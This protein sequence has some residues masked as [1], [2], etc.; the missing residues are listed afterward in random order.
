MKKCILLLVFASCATLA[1]A[2][3]R[4]GVVN[5]S[6]AFLHQKPDY[7]SPLETQA[8]MGTV[9][10]IIAEQGYWRQV[11]QHDPPYVAW[12][13]DLSLAEMKAPEVDAYFHDQKYIC[14]SP[15]SQVYSRPSVRSEILSELVMGDLVRIL[16]N[17]KGR[18]ERSAGFCLVLLPDGRAGYV[19]QRDLENFH[20]WAEKRSARPAN[21]EKTVRSFEGIPYM[22]GGVS[23]KSMDCSG[24]VWMTYFM[25]G[26]LLPRN[27]SQQAKCGIEVSLNRLK[28]GDLIFFGTPATADAP[29]RVA[30]VGISL[31]GKEFI[32]ASHVV[33]ICSLDS[34]A[35]NYYGNKIPLFAVRIV[36]PSGA[37]TNPARL[38][39]VRS[40]RTALHRDEIQDDGT[41]HP[42]Y[43]AVPLL[44]SPWYF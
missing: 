13:T 32:H 29:E 10:E 20:A 6:V 33:R 7:E 26:I 3:G 4:W 14:T 36:E 38:S 23:S 24:L 27:A 43:V 41:W 22:W 31:G 5:L 18:A 42:Q 2:Q 30:H 15:L 28:V 1:A 44:D 12:V 40:A 8:L 19:R 37:L 16:Y 35:P 21:L 9:V 17:E 25:N 34:R 39:M 11:V